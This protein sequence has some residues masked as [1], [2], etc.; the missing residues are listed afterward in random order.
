MIAQRGRI[1]LAT[2]TSLTADTSRI[3]VRATTH[4]HAAAGSYLQ[5]QIDQTRA[6]LTVIWDKRTSL[7]ADAAVDQVGRMIKP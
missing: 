7:A 1:E 6:K 2:L 5:Q 3:Y 4:H